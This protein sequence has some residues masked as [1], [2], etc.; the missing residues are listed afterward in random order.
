[1]ALLAPPEHA[2]EYL[3]VFALA[4]IVKKK[5]IPEL[6]TLLSESDDRLSLHFYQAHNITRLVQTRAWL[7]EQFVLEIW[8][9]YKLHQHQL[10][11]IAVGGFG[12]GDLQPKSDVDLLVLFDDKLPESAVTEFIQTLWDLGLELG[13]AVRTIGQCVVHAKEDVT[14]ATNLMEGRF[15]LGNKKM[16][17][18]MRVLT[19]DKHI[20]SGKEFFKAKYSEQSLRHLKCG[21]TAYN[22]EPNIKEGPG[23]LRDIQMVTWVA[24]RHFHVSSMHGLVDVGFLEPGEYINLQKG[25]RLLWK[26][27]FALHLLSGRKEDRILFE[28]QK[29]LAIIFNY[30]DDDI[31]LGVEKFMQEYYRNAMQLELLNMRLLQ[32]FK[33]NILFDSQDRQIRNLSN[34]CRSV[35]NFLEIK[36]PETLPEKPETLI[37]LFHLLQKHPEL[38]GIRAN[39]LRD[40]SRNLPIINSQFRENKHIQNLF[41]GLFKHKNKVF[42]QLSLMN[43]LGIL[44][45]YLPVFGKIIGRMQYDLFHMYTVD[46]HSLF[47]LRNLRHMY[48]SADKH[49]LAHQIINQFD[50]PYVIYLAGFFHDVAKGRGGDHAELGA[51][52]VGEFC[53]LHR[54][55]KADADLM[56]WLVKNHLIMSVV[57]QK[58]DISDPHVIK[59]FAELQQSQR[60][61]DAL[62]L[63]TIADISG[64]DPKLWNSFKDSLLSELYMR[65]KQF[66]T[67]QKFESRILQSKS[68]ALKLINTKDHES[69][70]QLWQKIPERFFNYA[71]ANKVSQITHAIL[72]NQYGQTVHIAEQHTDGFEVM[73]YSEDFK[74]LFHRV[75]HVFLA[76]RMN[77]VDAR[78]YSDKG[79]AL[80][81]FH[82]LGVYDRESLLAIDEDL[83]SVLKG[84]KLTKKM[85]PR[86]VSGREKH[87]HIEQKICFSNGRSSTESRMDV[88]CADNYALLS[89]ISE[90]LYKLNIDVHG[91]KIAT[92]GNR[93][94]DVFWL[95][96]N[97]KALGK[98]LQAKITEQ[99]IS[100]LKAISPNSN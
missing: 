71:S 88:S 100:N 6:K 55:P 54:I 47:V 90:V 59:K 2:D 11:L 17:K 51:I 68:K 34:N 40:I 87:F 35:N 16:F 79:I 37:E 7:V 95:S 24:Q 44:G 36:T 96:Y 81:Y 93:A 5:H 92:F 78:V 32:L 45:L 74:G 10:A 84:D 77:V 31:A 19:G 50:K 98:T 75:V 21:S 62:Y 18:A 56:A 22:L 91:A 89:L 69:V 73:I 83:C 42:E 99:L 38:D 94:E 26:I 66:L 9:S 46:Q 13:H 30:K 64:T 76:H 52:D 39:S 43:S 33:E 1:M 63:L 14:V 8:H 23:G 49:P 25:R 72:Q 29:K 27:R 4:T 20:W 86:I 3:D 28:Y 60:Q 48:Q 85:L 82:C 58:Q 97:N 70:Q 15:M 53:K 80:D 57:A 61:L 12:R 67:T 41:V 65:C